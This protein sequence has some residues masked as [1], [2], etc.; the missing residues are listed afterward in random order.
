MGKGGMKKIL[1]VS[2]LPL[3]IH[4]RLAMSNAAAADCKLVTVAAPLNVDRPSLISVVE[5]SA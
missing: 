3:A 5:R 1:T 4:F 2:N